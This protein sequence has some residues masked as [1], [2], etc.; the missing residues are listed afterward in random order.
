MA[1][2]VIGA[3]F[4]RT[5]TLSIKLALEQL[6]FGPCHHM[7]CV[8]EDPDS[9][10]DWQAAAEGKSADWHAVFDGYRSAI[11]W[12]AAHYWQ[13]L[14][15]VFPDA[16]VLLSVRPEDLWWESFSSTIRRLLQNR[17]RV[18]NP[19]VRSALKMADMIITE[20]TFYG[21]I[22][23]KESAISAYR[24]RIDDVKRTVAADR[25][26]EFD[27]SDGWEPLCRFL[28]VP[29]PASEF[30][31]GNSRS[32]FWQKFGGGLQPEERPDEGQDDK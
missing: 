12:P 29:V 9:H 30:P 2:S 23:S 14:A 21:D 20:Q 25:L 24:R 16:R 19:A 8:F 17:T 22:D 7:A 27:V 26:L 10:A 5:G 1:L 11:D 3:G 28:N 6:G 18:P 31:R 32:E 4:G 15:D 13:T